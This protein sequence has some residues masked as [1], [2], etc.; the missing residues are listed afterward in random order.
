MGSI[1]SVIGVGLLV[2][3]ASFPCFRDLYVILRGGGIDGECIYVYVG[4]AF[5]DLL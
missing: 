3:G 1:G 4:Y 5:E 2:L